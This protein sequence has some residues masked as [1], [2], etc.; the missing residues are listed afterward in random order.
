MISPAKI[1]PIASSA[2]TRAGVWK[3]LKQRRGLMA[4]VILLMIVTATVGLAIPLL[5]GT[6]VNQV[7]AKAETSALLLSAAGVLA[8]GLVGAG[9]GILSQVLLAKLC[10]GALAELRA[11]VFHA[12]VHQPLAQ[13]EAAG[14][15]DVVARV[16]GDVDAVSEAVTGILPAFIGAAFSIVLT[17]FGLGFLDWRLSLAVLVAVPL[18]VVATRIFLR[19]TKPVYRSLRAAEAQ[20]SG[21]IMETV[22]GADT[23]LALGVPAQHLSSVEESSKAAIALDI[24]GMKLITRFYNRLNMA[25]FLGMAAVL[26]VG[27]WLV[28]QG[29]ATVGAATTAALF[30]YRLFGPM[31]TVLGELDE[32]QKAGAGLSRMFGLIG[33]SAP[34]VAKA[35]TAATPGTIEL[36]S[37][38]FAHDG[39]KEVLHGINLFV[40]EGEQ[41]AVVGRS[42][43]GKSTLARLVMGIAQ[44][45]RGTVLTAGSETHLGPVGVNANGR[46][47]AA[48][49]S[50]EVHVFAGTIAENLRLAR[51]EATEAELRAALDSVGAEWAL[52]LGLDAELGDAGHSPTADK[53]QQLA[54]ARLLLADPVVAVLDEATAE[55]GNMAAKDLE[56]AAQA[57]MR[58][59]T[60]LVIAHNLDQAVAA[61]RVIVM[62]AGRIVEQGSHEQLRDASGAY[63]ELWRHWSASR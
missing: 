9:L 16:S 10:E 7:M 31:G 49:V 3:L 38:D 27:F 26:G 56:A 39:G 1:L 4:L 63:S 45:T 52:G 34:S 5:L 41:V 23:V 11:S 22:A 20:R 48:M 13:V 40:A 28:G 53:A 50:Q 30:F 35:P 8:A 42:G 33:M 44:P 24:R 6:M 17:L 46:L 54:M 37:V 29:S 19:A 57:A 51:S 55:A 58:G 61:D 43:A 12:A 15:G 2:E 36:R 60:S 25:E 21:Q 18:Q 62:E 47:R 59:R 32:L 14:R